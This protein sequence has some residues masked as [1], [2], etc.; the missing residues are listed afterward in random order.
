[1]STQVL[2]FRIVLASGTFFFAIREIGEKWTT[3]HQRIWNDYI[4]NFKIFSIFVRS[5]IQAECFW[6]D[7]WGRDFM[8]DKE[9]PFAVKVSIYLMSLL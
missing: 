2:S 7:T 5:W 4:Q 1:M 6:M 3:Q 8:G 9:A